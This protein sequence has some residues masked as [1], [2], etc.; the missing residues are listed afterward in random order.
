MVYNVRIANSAFI[1]C[2]Q[3]LNTHNTSLLLKHK[4]KS[5]EKGAGKTDVTIAKEVTS[6]KFRRMRNTFS[7]SFEYAMRDL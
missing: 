5:S 7:L 2:P 1:M 6:D 4:Q 3:I